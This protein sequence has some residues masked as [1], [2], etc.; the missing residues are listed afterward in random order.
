MALKKFFFLNIVILGFFLLTPKVNSQTIT[1]KIDQVMIELGDKKEEIGYI[2]DMGLIVGSFT[3]DDS[4]NIY[5]LSI[6][7]DC[8]KKY[9]RN[10]EYQKKYK[11]PEGVYINIIYHEDHLYCINKEYNKNDLYILSTDLQLL[12]TNK[13]IFS[14]YFNS[15]LLTDSKLVFDLK[16]GYGRGYNIYDLETGEIHTYQSTPFELHDGLTIK[17]YEFLA[18]HETGHEPTDYVGMVNNKWFLFQKGGWSP[19]KPYEFAFIKVNSNNDN[20]IIRRSLSTEVLGERIPMEGDDCILHQLK[21]LYVAGSVNDEY[22]LISKINLPV[23]FPEV[24]GEKYKKKTTK[25]SIYS[26]K[27]LRKMTLR[28]L[29]I[30]RNEIFARHGRIFRIEWLQKYFEKQPWY[31][32]NPT[33]SD[34]LLTEE[35]L[36]KIKLIKKI[37]A[38][39]RERGIN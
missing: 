29:K 5:V 16:G 19:D 3:V 15:M 37:E 30:L 38:E 14:D 24:Y 22:I 39:K 32:P 35:D 33:Y 9:S 20:K 36:E 12:E 8:I 21:W 31:Q 1:K 17:A 18:K 6:K 23:L 10:G 27:K 13:R 11:M 2:K 26:N 28:E 4:G 34:S 7:D 25:V